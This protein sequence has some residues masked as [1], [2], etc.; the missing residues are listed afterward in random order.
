MLLLRSTQTELCHFTRLPAFLV[1]TPW[2]MYAEIPVCTPRSALTDF[3]LLQT[4]FLPEDDRTSVSYKQYLAGIAVSMGG[5]IAEELSKFFTFVCTRNL[6]TSPYPSI[7]V[8]G[9]D[10]ISSGASSD[11]QQATRTAHSMVKVT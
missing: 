8:Y 10:N 2:V 11:I 4:A 9:E 1:A 5:R 3:F 6:A 7:A